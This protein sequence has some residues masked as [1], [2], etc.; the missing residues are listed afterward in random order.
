MRGLLT[1]TLPKVKQLKMEIRGQNAPQIQAQ[2]IFTNCGIIFPIATPEG[3]K[4]FDEKL[5]QSE[6]F[7]NAVSYSATQFIYSYFINFVF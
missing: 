1:D 4:T 6:V 2:S 3:L 5:Q 7:D